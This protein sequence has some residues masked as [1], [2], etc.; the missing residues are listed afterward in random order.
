MDSIKVAEYDTRYPPLQAGIMPTEFGNI[1]KASEAY[2]GTRY[3]ID[4]VQFW[5]R[6]LQVIPPSYKQS[7]D[8][9]RNELSFL[10]NMSA[11]S[12]FFYLLCLAAIFVNFATAQDPNLSLIIGNS[13][14]YIIAGLL[15]MFTNIFFYKAALFSVGDFGSMI[16][17]AYDL[18][19]L[20]LLRQFRI[21]HPKNSIEEF[22]VWRNLGEL[23]VLGQAS[24][25]YKPIKYEIKKDAKL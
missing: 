2:S 23:F 6:L 5:P 11:L 24:M 20:E 10:V 17:S 14:R 19:R 9:A 8:D 1:L 16:R 15:A 22:K 7:I 18:F 3:G 4:A 13:I 12:V 25:E 21:R